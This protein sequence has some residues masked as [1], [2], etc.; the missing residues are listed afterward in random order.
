M[1]GLLAFCWDNIKQASPFPEDACFSKSLGADDR[2]RT[3]DL[4]L[5]KALRYH[6]CHISNLI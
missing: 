4:R 1:G 3:G 2:I 6:L 5:T